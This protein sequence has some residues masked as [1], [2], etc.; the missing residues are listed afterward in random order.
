MPNHTN[1]VEHEQYVLQGA[2]TIGIGDEE[3]Q[4]KAGDV[5]YIPA[6]VPHW[7][8]SEGEEQAASKLKDAADKLAGNDTALQLRY[9]QT[10]N[11]MSSEHNQTIVFPLPIEILKAFTKN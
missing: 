4:V 8:R 10:L 1:T 11:D 2:A 5:V 7:Y 3:F 6:G 9:L